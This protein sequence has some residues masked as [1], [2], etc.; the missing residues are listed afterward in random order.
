[1]PKK[2]AVLSLLLVLF[3]ALIACGGG[4]SGAAKKTPGPPKSSLTGLV[5][6]D[7]TVLKRPVL[8][9][10]V[11]N[12]RQ[13]RPQTGLQYAD[14]VYEELA[15]GG[16]T[17]FIVLYQ[18]QDAKV[19]GPVRSARLVDADILLEYHAML[20][21]SG[22]HHIVQ[23]YLKKSGIV[24]LSHGKIGPPVFY[25]SKSRYA[26]HNLYTSTAGLWGAKD[27]ALGTPPPNDLFRFL[28]QPP[29]LPSPL[30]SGATA[31]PSPSSVSVG[32]SLQIPFS[33]QQTS[34]WKYNAT[35]DRYLRWQ[36]SNKHLLADG[37]QVQARNVLV[38]FVKVGETKIVD[39]AGHNSPD[40]VVIGSGSLRL[41]R[42]GVRVDGEWSRNGKEGRTR[43]TDLQGRP[44]VLAPGQTWVELVPTDVSVSA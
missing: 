15:E 19:V 43:L 12:S 28:E 1:V 3:L 33:G 18:S 22:A 38:L 32:T 25:R 35:V 6:G 9:V 17:R 39:A 21:Y 11:E 41:Y 14:V 2:T 5:V 10:K 29:L 26:P 40:V 4:K 20:A 31:S 36:G 23:D 27:A 16:I 7:P 24:L 42:N 13:A 37:A 44:L 8:A 34:I 30:P